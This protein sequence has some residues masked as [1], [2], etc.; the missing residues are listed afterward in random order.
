MNVFILFTLLNNPCRLRI[1]KPFDAPCIQKDFYRRTASWLNLIAEYSFELLYL[2][3][4]AKGRD[5]PSPPSC[6]H[7]SAFGSY[8]S[9]RT[10]NPRDTIEA[11]AKISGGC[12]GR[13]Y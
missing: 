8:A 2:F 13:Q 6:Q 11:D 3:W 10:V 4:D 1:V 7:F 9:L 12:A 5:I